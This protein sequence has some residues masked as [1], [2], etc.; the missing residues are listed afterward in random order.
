MGR[1]KQD[2]RTCDHDGGPALIERS[3]EEG[4]CRAR[5]VTCGTVGPPR[6]TAMQAVQA[7]RERG[8]ESRR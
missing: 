6:E 2:P 7:L 8:R 1:G 5:C 3:G 4:A